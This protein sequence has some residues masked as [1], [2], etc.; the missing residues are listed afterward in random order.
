MIESILKLLKEEGISEYRINETRRQSAELFFIKKKLDMRR[1][2]DT[3]GILVTVYRDFTE[4]GVTYKGSCG[5]ELAPDL[6]GAEIRARI[7]SAYFAAGFVK[8]PYYHL[9]KGK[10]RP[11]INMPAKMSEQPLFDSAWRMADALFL[12]DTETDAFLNSAEIFAVKSDVRILNSNGIDVS[13]TRYSLNGEFIAQAPAPQDVE[14]Y[15]SFGYDDVAPEALSELSR[16][17]LLR[18]RARAEAV[19]APKAGEYTVLLSDTHVCTVLANYLERA[20]ASMIYA[21]YV[22]SAVGK[23]IQGGDVK[24]EK[25]QLSLLADAPYDE[26]G[27]P[28]SE[29]PLVADGV[30][31]CLPGASR[32]AEYLGAEQVGMYRRFGCQNGSVSAAEL[33]KQP[34]LHVVAFSDFQ[35]DAFSGYFGGEIRLAFLFDGEKT[36]AVTGGSINGSLLEKQCDLCF[37]KERYSDSSYDGPALLCLHGI[38]VAGA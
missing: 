15:F 28:L 16:K 14:L 33:Q 4:D 17:A 2:A 31:Q 23:S 32:F 27:V 38:R 6:T 30:L 34:H 24:G 22:D 11:H 3:H 21:G 29:R 13:Y 35:M 5:A 20:D 1:M 10:K 7:Q 19:S 8:N 37:S 12:P 26:E 25:L 36:T 18:V 9:P